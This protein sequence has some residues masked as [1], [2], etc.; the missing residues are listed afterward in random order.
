[1]KKECWIG[2]SF[3]LVG[4]IVL[5]L[6]ACTTTAPT[7]TNGSGTLYGQGAKGGQQ[8][9]NGNGHVQS[10]SNADG[11]SHELQNKSGN[12]GATASAIPLR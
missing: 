2:V 7:N 10:G 9:G 3:L 6:T 8:D 1:M 4:A 12:A 5:A 11:S